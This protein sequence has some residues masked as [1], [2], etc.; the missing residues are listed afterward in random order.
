MSLFARIVNEEK[1]ENHFLALV[2][3]KDCNAQSIFD[4]VNVFFREENFDITKVR[5]VVVDGCTMMSGQNTGARAL[6]EEV[7]PFLVYVHCWNHKVGLCFARLILKYEDYA[8]FVSLPLNVFF[9]F[10]NSTVKLSIFDE[11]QGGLCLE[12]V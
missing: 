9:M 4:S 11:V 3:L 10:K 1:T 8:K 2:Q 7:A 5:F 12:K 6:L